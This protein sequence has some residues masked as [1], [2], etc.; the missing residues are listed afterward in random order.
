MNWR[1]HAA[2]AA[3][4]TFSL[5]A[6][7]AAHF[8]SWPLVDRLVPPDTLWEVGLLLLAIFAPV[9]LGTGLVILMVPVFDR[10]FH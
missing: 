1:R 8:V 9:Y 6:G 2:T 10:W 3:S 4:L 7:V 5:V